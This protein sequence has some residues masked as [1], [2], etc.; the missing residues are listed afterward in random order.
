MPVFKFFMYNSAHNK[1]DT[2]S[3]IASYLLWTHVW[4]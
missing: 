2:S 3:Y 4:W 1:V